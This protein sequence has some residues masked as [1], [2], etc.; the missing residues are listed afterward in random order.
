M[1]SR[2]WSGTARKERAQEYIVHLQHETF[3]QLESMKGF[4]KA[5]ILKR[6]TDRGTEFLIITEWDSLAT[7]QQ[8]AGEDVETAVVPEFVQ[9][10][11]V[12]YERRA[13]HYEISFVSSAT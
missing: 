2:H 10:L 4:V 7:I 8:F 11:M 1:I 5:S 13:R 9:G 6:E 12:D 3:P